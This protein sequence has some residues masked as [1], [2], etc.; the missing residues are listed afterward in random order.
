VLWRLVNNVGH[1][2][3][4]ARPAAGAAAGGGAASGGGGAAL[5]NALASLPCYGVLADSGLIRAAAARVGPFDRLAQLVV[6]SAVA[7]LRTAGLS[8][9]S[10]GRVRVNRFTS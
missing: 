9:W 3:G 7:L 2:A 4:M 6:S 5:Q 8:G 10:D 1:R